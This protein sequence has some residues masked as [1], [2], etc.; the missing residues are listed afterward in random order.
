MEKV[1]DTIAGHVWGLPLI[2]LLVGT[3]GLGSPV[4]MY[5]AAAGIGRLGLVDYD[6]VDFTNL[7]RQI[8]HGTSAIGQLKV[9]SARD[10]LLD[11]NPEVHID[12]FNEPFT[13]ENGLQIAEPYDLII[14]G[15]KLLK[16]EV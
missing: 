13:S 16:G 7:Q 3:G 2:V 5:L 10:R 11:I 8:V 14:D 12:V 9:D 4:G 6:I 1:L 15:R